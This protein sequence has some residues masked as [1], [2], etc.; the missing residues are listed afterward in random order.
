MN[1]AI[2]V[3]FQADEDAE[4]GNRLDAAGNLVAL[5]ILRSEGVPRILHALLDAQRDATTLLVDIQHHDLDLI[6]QLDDF[7]R[8]HVLV[9]PIHFGDVN[10]ALDTLFELGKAAVV[11]EVGNTRLD[12]AAFGVTVGDFDPRIFAQLLEAEG[13]PVALA[14]E[15]EDLDVDFLTHFDDLGGVLDTLPR[16]VGN[17]QQTVNTTQVHERAVVCEVL[18]NTL[19]GHAFL[20]RLKQGFTLNAVG[21]FHHGAAGHHH[22]VALL[23]QLDDLEFEFL[24][25]Q[26]RGITNRAHINQRARKERA[27][28]IDINSKATFDL[29]VDNTL[30]HFVR[31]VRG[32]EF[33]PGLGTLGFFAGQLGL[34]ETVFHGFQRYLDFI[35][36]AEGA[37]ARRVDELGTRN[38][39]F[40][41]QPGMDG[42]PLVIDVDDNAGDNAARLHLDGLQAFFKEFSERFAHYTLPVCESTAANRLAAP[43]AGTGHPLKP[44]PATSGTDLGAAR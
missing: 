2:D 33:F 12:A 18:D 29:A 27:D 21:R 16:H 14:I 42:D 20:Q 24:V 44:T 1:Q 22:V 25:L 37:V 9:G 35:A 6:T 41:L 17:V 30:D 36:D 4:V 7:G 34:T 13:N 32:F 28:G 38:H 3:A 39:A 40:G 11:G 31:L 23:V 26:V 15:L 8:V 19:D 10:Q 43:P 5:G